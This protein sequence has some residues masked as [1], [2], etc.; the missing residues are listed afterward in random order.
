MRALCFFLI[1]ASSA[2]AGAAPAPENLSRLPV[3]RQRALCLSEITPEGMI[4]HQFGDE[5]R[6]GLYDFATCSELVAKS[7]SLCA[8]F[9]GG[10]S[11]GAAPALNLKRYKVVG[12]AIADQR[13]FE[14]SVCDSRSAGYLLLAGLVAG[15]PRDSLLPFA[16]RMLNVE[17]SVKAEDLVDASSEVYHSRALR[18]G[19][20]P[21][22]VRRGFFNYLLG[23]VACAGIESPGLRRECEWKGAAVDA[24][25]AR[26][27]S[28]CRSRDL[29]CLALFDGEKA[30]RAVG[31][32]AVRIFCTKE[33]PLLK[34]SDAQWNVMRSKL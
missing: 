25:R 7:P 13:V 32:Q 5:S 14:Y 28:L 11:A 2:R 3:E 8:Y 16:R 31:R 33:F 26:D 10:P 21:G 27:R 23:G 4:T 6:E 19:K 9:P 12:G 24:L 20:L 18:P 34:P 29:M 15:E 17:P 1:T 22:L 30:C